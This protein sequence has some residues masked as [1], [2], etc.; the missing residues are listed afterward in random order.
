MSIKIQSKGIERE[1]ESKAKQ[2]DTQE[3]S[4]IEREHKMQR[5]NSDPRIMQVLQVIIYVECRDV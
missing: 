5:D 1:G 3:D 4:S 2:R